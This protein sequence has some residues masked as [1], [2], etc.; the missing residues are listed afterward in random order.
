MSLNKNIVLL[1]KKMK[2]RFRNNVS[3][4]KHNINC[5]PVH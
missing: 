3:R 4:L 2:E 1:V 5:R